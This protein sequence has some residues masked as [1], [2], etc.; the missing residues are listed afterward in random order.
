MFLQPSYIT[1]GFRPDSKV[2]VKSWS[3]IV[4]EIVKQQEQFTEDPRVQE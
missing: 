4:D 3:A 2:G 1:E